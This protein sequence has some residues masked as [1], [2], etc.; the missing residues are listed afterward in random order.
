MRWFGSLA[1]AGLCIAIAQTRAADDEKKSFLDAGAWEGL[2]KEYWKAEGDTVVGSSLGGEGLKFNTFLC[3]KK[4]YKDFEMSFKVRLKDGIGNS[5]IQIRSK[6]HDMKK[7]AVSGPQCDI[8]K[9]YWGSLYGENFGGMMKAA[10]ADKVNAKLGEKDFNDY[11]IKC[12]GKKVTITV[13]G[14]VA[15]DEEFPK[16]P[17]E[18][19]IAFQMHAGPP[20]E[21]TFKDIKFTDLSK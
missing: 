4:P 14:V 18:G 13:N 9:N 1:L 8:G 17:E 6:V 12:V 11:A 7:F 10:P 5:G 16:L 21:V 20:M 19:I 15:V 3:S 2:V